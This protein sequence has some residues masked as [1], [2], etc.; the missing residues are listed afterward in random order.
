MRSA[1]SNQSPASTSM[2]GVDISK[3]LTDVPAVNYVIIGGDAQVSF[4]AYCRHISTLF[5]DREISRP[6]RAGANDAFSASNRPGSLLNLYI[7]STI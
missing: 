7:G 2:S 1:R 3:G 4:C 5:K 6:E